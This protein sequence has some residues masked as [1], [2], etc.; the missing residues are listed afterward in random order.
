MSWD[1]ARLVYGHWKNTAFLTTLSMVFSDSSSGVEPDP[2][3]DIARSIDR[4]L[5]HD[6]SPH[7][8]VL[9]APIKDSK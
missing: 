5:G 6:L 9:A 8:V 3:P 2:F 1:G 7:M 4:K